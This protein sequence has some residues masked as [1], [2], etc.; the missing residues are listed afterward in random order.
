ML[1]G[2]T[3]R[4]LN[5]PAVNRVA[6]SP[7][8]SNPANFIGNTTAQE[9]GVR[10]R[11]SQSDDSLSLSSVLQSGTAGAVA[12]T[13]SEGA[14][15][16]TQQPEEN[17]LQQQVEDRL[18]EALEEASNESDLSVRFRRDEDTGSTLVQFIEP[19]SGDVVR[20]FPPEDVLK[21]AS[22][23]QDLTGDLFAA[24]TEDPNVSG[25]FL[26]DQA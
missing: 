16:S 23:F 13:E 17:N 7:S 11:F 9:E 5:T 12:E 22:R 24:E 14:V 25:S 15:K 21:F 8:S 2:E 19:E 4:V 1:T 20:Q 26:N 18:Q 10:A 3:A 6:S